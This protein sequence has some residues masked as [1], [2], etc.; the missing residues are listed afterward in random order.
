VLHRDGYRCRRCGSLANEVHHVE[1]GNED[2]A[3]MVSLCPDCHLA[4]TLAQAAAARALAR[5]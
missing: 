1:P 5:P 3:M 2:E 4:V